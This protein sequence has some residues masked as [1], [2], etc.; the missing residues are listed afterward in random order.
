MANQIRCRKKSPTTQTLYIQWCGQVPCRSDRG[1][2]IL[3]KTAELEM[4]TLDTVDNVIGLEMLQRQSVSRAEIL[5]KLTTQIRNKCMTVSS[6]FV[7]NG[8]G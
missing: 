5:T 4:P 2:R 7:T 8:K 3:A 1:S 6:S